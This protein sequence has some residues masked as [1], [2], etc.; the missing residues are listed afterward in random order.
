MF[1]TSTRPHYRTLVTTYI[2]EDA[3]LMITSPGQDQR[4]MDWMD[5]YIFPADKSGV[6]EPD[7][8]YGGV[9]VGGTRE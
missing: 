2:T 1:V 4:L 6:E 9:L 5:R 3:V 8:H 7:G